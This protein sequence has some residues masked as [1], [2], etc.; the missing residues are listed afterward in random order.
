MTNI[1]DILSDIS[2]RPFKIP[3]GKWKYY[4]EWNNAL[5]FHWTIPFDILPEHLNIDTFNGE[6]YVSLVA[7]TMEKIRP[8]FLPAIGIY[9]KF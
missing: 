1:E 9:F 4:Q 5:F 3:N 8:R 6:C 7:F 2:H